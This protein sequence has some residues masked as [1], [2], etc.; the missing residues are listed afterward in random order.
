MLTGT[1]VWCSTIAFMNLY[2]GSAS[3]F[4]T[5]ALA[6][7]ILLKFVFCVSTT[8]PIEVYYFIV[9]MGF[10]FISTLV[11][12]IM[13]RL[14]QTGT[15]DGCSLLR[16]DTGIDVKAF[17]IFFYSY[18][19]F[20]I[21]FCFATVVAFWITM[22]LMD[23][24]S[25]QRQS[26]K[27]IRKRRHLVKRVMIRIIWYPM[28]PIVTQSLQI[29][30][31]MYWNDDLQPTMSNI[32]VV[33]NTLPGLLNSLVFFFDPAVSA[34]REDV[35]VFLLN[36][37]LF[38]RNELDRSNTFKTSFYTFMLYI[39]KWFLLRKRDLDQLRAFRTRH[40]ENS[41]KNQSA[42]RAMSMDRVLVSGERRISF[43]PPTPSWENRPRGMNPVSTLEQGYDPKHFDTETDSTT[44]TETELSTLP[45]SSSQ[46]PVRMQNV[47]VPQEKP[48]PRPMTRPLSQL[49]YSVQRNSLDIP[50][51]QPVQVPLRRNSL[52]YVPPPS[53]ESS[54]F[55]L[56]KINNDELLPSI[57][58]D[59]AFD[60]D[61]D[62]F[63]S[64]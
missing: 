36:R 8:E 61:F 28:I 12:G 4:T 26:T 27:R 9:G 35:R 34:A 21:L 59:L 31:L 2:S 45:P 30:Q 24:Q 47:Y 44:I 39:C 51:S 18:I 42:E 56:P 15:L 3:A 50:P 53:D 19:A 41:F 14:G 58:N 10:P 48:L 7:H 55:H 62:K 23:K 29:F 33:L 52:H 46:V 32:A 63:G 57:S 38:G 43:D 49:R 64:K 6:L 16:L 13:G 40:L 5:A 54:S 17:W 25:D 22:L 60:V 20:S 11:A 1:G 37:Y